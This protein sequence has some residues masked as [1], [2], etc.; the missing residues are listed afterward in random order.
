MSLKRKIQRNVL[1][2]LGPEFAH[3]TMII[4]DRKDGRFAWAVQCQRTDKIL[5]GP[6]G[7]H[8]TEEQAWSAGWE[9]ALKRA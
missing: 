7:R 3:A 1:R 2:K 9:E 5:I 6:R 4:V 8:D